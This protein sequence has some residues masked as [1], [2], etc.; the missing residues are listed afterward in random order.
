M[1]PKMHLPGLDPQKSKEVQN[2]FHFLNL[3]KKVSEKKQ[4]E[5]RE[6]RY[7]V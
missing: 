2:W 7:V 4:V 1:L 6:S 5:I 3:R